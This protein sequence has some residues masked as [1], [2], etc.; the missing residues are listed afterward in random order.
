V[1]P[2]RIG[3]IGFCFGGMVALE[4]GRMGADL[5]GIATFHG[6]LS[7]KNPAGKGAFKGPVLVMNGADD[8]FVPRE[9]ID[10]FMDEMRKA[11]A[12]WEFVNFGGAVHCFAE[13]DEHGALKGCM[14]H[15]PSYKRS[16][17]LM[18]GFFNESFAKR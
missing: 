12:D 14:F 16:V 1:D 13:P 8:S 5:D 11:D 10:G 18:H 2:A 15:A 17:F 3:A 7:T 9:Q 6:N 4:M